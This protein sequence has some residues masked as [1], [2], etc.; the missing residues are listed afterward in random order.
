M[1]VVGPMRSNWYW[2]LL[3]ALCVGLLVAGCVSVPAEFSSSGAG[4]SRAMQGRGAPSDAKSEAADGQ[5]GPVDVQPTAAEGAV[6]APDGAVEAPDAAG[7]APDAAIPTVTSDPSALPNPSTPQPDTGGKV[8][9]N[10]L[11]TATLAPSPTVPPTP[12]AD[13]FYTTGPP[14]RLEIPAIGVVASVELVGLTRDRAMDVPKGW[15][16]VGWYRDGY[17]PGEP[18]NAVFAGHLDTSSGGP[19]V[20]WSL[21]QLQPGD[22]VIVSYQ[23][24]DRY[25]FLVEGQEMYQYDAQGPIIDRIFGDSLTADLNLVTCDGA[26]DHGQATYTHRL[27]VF[28][29]LVPDRT[30]RSDGSSLPIE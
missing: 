15:M 4:P 20:F 8:V 16:N 24:G 1:R 29:T 13:P 12:T 28:T 2:A 3:P 14:V 25:T 30:V 22:E 7:E 26:W 19:A 6:E 21:D 18:G 23:N 9:A 5:S 17:R 10:P 11:P 27:V